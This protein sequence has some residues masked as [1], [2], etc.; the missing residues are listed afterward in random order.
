M[1]TYME[2][3]FEL[4]VRSERDSITILSP[5]FFVAKYVSPKVL[6]FITIHMPQ[7]TSEILE[8]QSPANQKAYFQIR[9]RK[10]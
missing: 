1:A 4:H 2:T 5:I 3:M 10:H 6:K 9:F 7:R 8:V